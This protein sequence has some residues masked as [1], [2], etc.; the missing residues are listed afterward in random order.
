MIEER[1]PRA[2]KHREVVCSGPAERSLRT[3]ADRTLS[4]LYGRLRECPK[5]TLAVFRPAR[6]RLSPFRNYCLGTES[7]S[8]PR[9]FQTS[10]WR[11]II[12]QGVCKARGAVLVLCP[13]LPLRCKRRN[14]YIYNKGTMMKF[15]KLSGQVI[16]VGN[17]LIVFWT[18]QLVLNCL[19][20]CV[21]FPGRSIEQKLFDFN[22]E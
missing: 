7:N 16:V 12:F 21:L 11:E 8:R 3:L 2:V 1:T 4:A 10:S 6:R 14:I 15:Y 17:R 13:S 19:E 5:R 9:S 22:G 20:E 18:F